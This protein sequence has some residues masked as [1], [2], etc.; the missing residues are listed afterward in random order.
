[1]NPG[2]LPAGKHS[3]TAFAIAPPTPDASR[4]LFPFLDPVTLTHSQL[5]SDDLA[6]GTGLEDPAVVEGRRKRNSY[7]TVK[8]VGGGAFT[9]EDFPRENI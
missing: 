5:L 2:R 1:M 3:S 9:L 6:V 4:P 7:K 8:V